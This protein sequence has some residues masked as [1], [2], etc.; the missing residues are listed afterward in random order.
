MESSIKVLKQGNECSLKATGTCRWYRRVL[1]LL[2]KHCCSLRCWCWSWSRLACSS[3]IRLHCCLHG[4][5]LVGIV[6]W[7]LW[8]RHSAPFLDPAA[9]NIKDFLHKADQRRTTLAP[10]SPSVELVASPLPGK[11][12]GLQRHGR[13][14]GS[15][16]CRIVSMVSWPQPSEVT[17][18]ARSVPPRAFVAFCPSFRS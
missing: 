10:A 2:L 5:T 14:S 3:A 17:E 18:T 11:E 8:W 7:H 13:Q 9:T 12:A 6:D 16:T 15:R 1:K 4:H